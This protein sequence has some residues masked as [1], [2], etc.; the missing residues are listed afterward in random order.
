[1][2]QS[3]AITRSYEKVKLS[4]PSP[5]PWQSLADCAHKTCLSGDHL[6]DTCPLVYILAS[7]FLLNCVSFYCKRYP[8][9]RGKRKWVTFLLPS[10]F[11]LVTRLP[12]MCGR[13]PMTPSKSGKGLDLGLS[14]LSTREDGMVRLFCSE[15]M[16][17]F[18][19]AVE[20]ARHVQYICVCLLPKLLFC[21]R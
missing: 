13:S 5:S 21:L 8:R 2:W 7:P 3:P 14:A 10:R 18:C 6:P 16:I 4:P 17:G 12:P 11:R 9:T 20:L 15:R 1:M 19:V